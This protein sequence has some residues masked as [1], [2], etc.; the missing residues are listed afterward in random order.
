[1]NSNKT[2]CP[3]STHRKNNS[4]KALAKKIV[5]A[6]KIAPIKQAYKNDTTKNSIISKNNTKSHGTVIKKNSKNQEIYQNREK[7][8]IKI[9]ELKFNPSCV[10]PFLGYYSY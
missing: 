8:S 6:I 3:R 1:M 4:E 2:K 5:P 7:D 10:F 9:M